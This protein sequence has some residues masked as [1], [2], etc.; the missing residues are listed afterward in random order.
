MRTKIYTMIVI[1]CALNL[2]FYRAPVSAADINLKMIIMP[3]QCSA[4][5]VHDGI[6]ELIRVTPEACRRA[7]NL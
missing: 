4:E 6:Q 2:N 7:L 5:R 1:A 3:L